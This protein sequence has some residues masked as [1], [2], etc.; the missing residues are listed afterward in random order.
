MGVW[1]E[2]REDSVWMCGEMRAESVNQFIHHCKYNVHNSIASSYLRQ[3]VSSVPSFHRLGAGEWPLSPCSPSPPQE[4]RCQR[5]APEPWVNAEESQEGTRKLG[6][7]IYPTVTP[8]TVITSLTT[9][10]LCVNFFPGMY[11][12]MYLGKST[13][14]KDVPEVKVHLKDREST[15]YTTREVTFHHNEATFVLLVRHL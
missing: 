10:S 4:P 1:G 12:Y 5:S 13:Q 2:G 3:T 7:L 9:T 11:M 15:G 14:P 8:N 6:S